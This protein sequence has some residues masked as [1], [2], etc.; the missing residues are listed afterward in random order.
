MLGRL[1][2]LSHHFHIACEQVATPAARVEANSLVHREMMA[3]S[4]DLVGEIAAHGKSSSSLTR[5]MAGAIGLTA[6]SDGFLQPPGGSAWYGTLVSPSEVSPHL[7]C[8]RRSRVLP[9]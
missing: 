7:S 3:T 8:R 6:G 4:T 2:S 1:R 5:R 9:P